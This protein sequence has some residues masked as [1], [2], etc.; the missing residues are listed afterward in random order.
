VA[1]GYCVIVG[2]ST[3]ELD[4]P[5][6]VVDLERTLNGG[7]SCLEMSCHC[8]ELVGSGVPWACVGSGDDGGCG[9][10]GCTIPV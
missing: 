8:E 5:M 3:P 9:D 4:G 6:G 7:R 10:I 1:L 2:V